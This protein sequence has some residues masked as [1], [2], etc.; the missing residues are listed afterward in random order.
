MEFQ[1]WIKV[2]I[3]MDGWFHS[4][5]YLRTSTQGTPSL[6]RAEPSARRPSWRGSY[7]AL[8]RSALARSAPLVWK[9]YDFY[10]PNPSKPTNPF[11]HVRMIIAIVRLKKVKICLD[12]LADPAPALLYEGPA[13]HRDPLRRPD[14]P[15]MVQ[16]R[17]DRR[18][19]RYRSSADQDDR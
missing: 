1:Y 2:K 9:I 5:S 4:C 10:Q 12:G 8:A 7:S 19:L 6:Q 18:R 17:R 16:K 13:L 11:L 3:W 15:W 14:Q